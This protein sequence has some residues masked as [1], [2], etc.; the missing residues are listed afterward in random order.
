MPLAV[1]PTL[2]DVYTLLKAFIVGIV[3]AGVQVVKGL[4]NRTAMP[5]PLPGFVAMTAVLMNPHRTPV[6]TW[7]HNN[8][9]PDAISIE[10]GILLRVQLDC[11]GPDAA[12][13]AVA[14]ATLRSS[15]ACDVLAPVAPLFADNPIQAPL[16]NAE[17][18]YEQRWIVGA[19]LQYNPVV[20]T[21]MQFADAAEVNLINIDVRFPP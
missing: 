21:P 17:A 14:L 9:E 18:E 1:A 13:W 12:Q 7:D 3:P 11:Y 16:T 2:Q 15:Y 5:L 4:N 10:Q 20:S 8:P 19:N 6:E